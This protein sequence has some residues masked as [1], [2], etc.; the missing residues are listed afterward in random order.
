MTHCFPMPSRSWRHRIR[1]FEASELFIGLLCRIP[2][3]WNCT[4]SERKKASLACARLAL[5]SMS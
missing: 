1:A 2:G 3:Q 5:K 4:D